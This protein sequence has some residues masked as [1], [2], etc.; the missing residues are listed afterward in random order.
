MMNHG[1]FSSLVLALV[2]VL[3]LFPCAYSR[4]QQKQEQPLKLKAELVQFVVLVTNKAGNPVT[5]LNK[6]DFALMERGK[7]QDISFFSLVDSVAGPRHDLAAQPEGSAPAAP[8]GVS[9]GRTIFIIL[10]PYF[11]RRTSYAAVERTL[12]RLI[13]EDLLPGDQVAIFSTSG[14]LA[15]FQQ[16]TKNKRVMLTAIHAFFGKSEHLA[17]IDPE[18]ALAQQDFTPAD[19]DND[20]RDIHYRTRGSLRTLVSVLKAASDVP[21]RKVAFFIS[22]SSSIKV[23]SSSSN[24]P[25]E[26]ALA[27]LR[28][29][30][31]ESRKHGMTVYTIDPRGLGGSVREGRVSEAIGTP[32]T[33]DLLGAQ[34]SPGDSV[35]SNDGFGFLDTVDCGCLRMKL[36]LNSPY[37]AMAYYPVNPLDNEQLR[38][39]KIEVKGRPDL[40]AYSTGF[41]WTGGSRD[42]KLAEA[43]KDKRVSKAAAAIVPIHDLDIAITHAVAVIDEKTGERAAQMAISIDPYTWPFQTDGADHVASFEVVGF[44][45]D[46]NN[47]LIGGYDKDYVL[48]LSP[49]DL[50]KAMRQCL[51]L[52]GEIN[53]KRQGL[54]SL[55]VVVID[56]VTNRLGSATEWVLAQ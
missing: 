50:S 7:Q 27:D 36:S 30:I 12:A 35:A 9:A 46:V 26:L 8:V 48:R 4:P 18:L 19:E 31:E 11:I 2:F 28:R 1:K 53:L 54:Y 37:Y 40:N 21:G 22:E 13:D 10:D 45:Y 23:I 49:E 25:L 41:L 33:R 16:A 38:E 52:S 51:I 14:K 29:E 17:G 47:N 5:D 44:A 3:L 24:S 20:P 56:K 6:D 34:Q 32:A 42:K 39:V 43:P 15:G 55:R